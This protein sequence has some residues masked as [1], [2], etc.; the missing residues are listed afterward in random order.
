MPVAA[1]RAS[2][3]ARAS[4][5][6][7]PTARGPYSKLVVDALTGPP[8]P[9]AVPVERHD[10][11]ALIDD[12]LHLALYCCYELHYRGFAGV[13]PEWEWW[14]SLLGLRR[15]LERAFEQ[16]LAEEVGPI[17]PVLDVQAALAQVIDDGGGP[18]LSGYMSERGTLQQMREFCIHRSAYQLKEADPHT[19]GIPRITGEAKAAMVEIQADEYGEGSLADMHSTLFAGTM[20]ALGLDTTYGAYLDLLPGTTL[21]TVNLVSMFGLHRQWRG[22]LVGHLALFEMTSVMPMGRYSRA[23]ERLGLGTEARR[24]YDVHVLAD[25]VH[26]VVASERL[27]AGLVADEPELA[28]D[29]VF[30]ARAV[31]AL[32]ARFAAMLLDAWRQGENSLRPA[33]G[34]PRAS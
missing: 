4:A 17:D 20:R 5:P 25:A 15:T 28:E 22:A 13:D 14:P 9:L 1:E 31:M 18:S 8:R 11:D 30:G 23:L 3:Q 33:P 12:D 29:V 7:L 24:F 34:G 16:R 6:E 2:S 27:A 32:E 10:I 21:A 26:E 19:W